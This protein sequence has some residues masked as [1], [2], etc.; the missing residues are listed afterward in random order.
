MIRPT[1]IAGGHAD[2]ESRTPLVRMDH[3][4]I[5]TFL[6]L[7]VVAFLYFAGSFLKPLALAMLL[8]FAL[9]PVA[10]FLERRGVPRVPAVVLTVVIGL[11]TLAGLGLVVW[12]QM[13]ALAERADVLAAN[14]DRQLDRLLK[15][16]PDSPLEK[17]GE[18]GQKVTEQIRTGMEGVE[19]AAEDLPKVQVVEATSNREKLESAF[20]PYVEIGGIAAFVLILVLFILMQREELSDRIVQLFGSQHVS[21][22]TRT[23]DELGERIS[24]YLGM[25]TLVNAT[26]GLIVGLG[27]WAIGVPF[28]AL[29][30]TLAAVLRYVPYVGPSVAFALPLLFTAGTTA[31]WVKP[32]EVIVLFAVMETAA[33]V[34]IEPVVYGKT[35]GISALGLLVAAM[36]W[37]WLWGPVGLLLS[38]PLTVCLAVLGK[39][40]PALGAFWTL[41]GETSDMPPDMRYYQRVLARDQD[42]AVELV[43]ELSAE[44]SRIQV[45][46][47]VLIPALRLA[48]RDAA[49]DTI[50]DQDRALLWWTTRELV[51]DLEDR[52][53]AVPAADGEAEA[54]RRVLGIA[55]ST[56]SDAIP[57]EMLA[58][59]LDGS[60]V[61]LEVVETF[62][63]PLALAEKIEAEAPDALLVSHLPPTGFT[64]A[65]YLVK[66][67]HARLPSL[68]IVVG[69]WDPSDDTKRSAPKF[70]EAGAQKVV[71]TLPE[72]RAF[73][74][75]PPEAKNIQPIAATAPA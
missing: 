66:R 2:V 28:A 13:G 74:A 48:E 4:V 38:T 65:R 18:L 64:A 29:W 23:I 56:R 8:C 40:V 67:L 49:Q 39:S 19:S 44:R 59:E 35:T 43:E 53:A 20:G 51:E 58:R 6:I 3:P 34:F 52:A 7:A 24:R 32:L 22:T 75:T 21:L 42:G 45:F 25:L 57:L 16:N 15:T 10:R 71:H 62:D 27:L 5:I 11:G 68:P 36:F 69:L 9:A 26:Q 14:I 55:A 33:N 17:L 63:S 46:D 50:A 54:P 61:A 1:F 73:L 37:T 47:E 60:A 70:T 72:A 30:G 31:S 41:L 12:S